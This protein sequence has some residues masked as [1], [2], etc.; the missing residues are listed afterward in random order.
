MAY[1]ILRDVADPDLVRV[2][3]N[4]AAAFQELASGAEVATKTMPIAT[5]PMY[6]CTGAELVLFVDQ[7]GGRVTV[8]LPGSP[9]HPLTIRSISS[10]TN[11]VTV[12]AAGT[13][14][15]GQAPTIDGAS[16]LSLHPNQ[17][18]RLAFD[19]HSWWSI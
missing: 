2:Q 19:S 12:M 15:S 4:V 1:K 11:T 14:P 16:L 3:Q 18:V 5:G 10:S 8:V 13:Q 17:T 7:L 6:R 9:T